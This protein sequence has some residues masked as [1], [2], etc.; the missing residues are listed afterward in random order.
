MA[1]L[2]EI[3]QIVAEAEK[4]PAG[5][6]RDAIISEAMALLDQTKEE[7]PLWQK[8]LTGAGKVLDYAGGVSR[9]ALANRPEVLLAEALASDKPVDAKEQAMRGAE[10]LKQA[11]MASPKSSSELMESRGVGEMGSTELPL[12]GKVTGRGTV[13]LLADVATD[14]TTY[15][16]AAALKPLIKSK[17]K[18]LYRSGLKNIDKAVWKKGKDMNAFS[19]AAMKYG[20]RGSAE[21]IFN[22]TDEVLEKL[23]KERDAILADAAQ[24]GAVVDTERVLKPVVRDAKKIATSSK[25][26]DSNVKSQAAKMAD[27]LEA[28]AEANKRIPERMPEPEQVP[29][30]FPEELPTKKTKVIK[31][32]FVDADEPLKSMS[33]VSDQPLMPEFKLGEKQSEVA[34]LFND[35]PAAALPEMDQYIKWLDRKGVTPDE[36]KKIVSE[37]QAAEK[38]PGWSN[39]ADS[40]EGIKQ[41]EMLSRTLGYEPEV[42][43]SIYKQKNIAPLIVEEGAYRAA[44]IAEQADLLNL[45]SYA[46]K[47][48]EPKTTT[49]RFLQRKSIINEGQQSLLRPSDVMGEAVPTPAV[50]GLTPTE[51][52]AVK[53]QLYNMIGSEPYGILRQD[54]K[55]QGL[56]KKAA[57]RFNTATTEAVRKVDPKAAKRLR[58]LNKDMSGLLTGRPAAWNEASK[59]ITKNMVTSVDAPLA[60]LNPQAYL[61]KKAADI[62]KTASFRTN[63]G[64]ALSNDMIAS[65]LGGVGGAG[66]SAAKT[67]AINAYMKPEEE[68]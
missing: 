52:S 35:T 60:L 25:V 43:R 30:F 4:L 18:D 58:E 45:E 65:L 26:I 42:V 13:G 5:A 61:G 29:A 28:F 15:V 12:L 9:A 3:E 32:T 48:L 41:F 11:L 40:E 51:S 27:D 2:K 57:A 54:K 63:V 17:G 7:T 46:S 38:L 33:S 22:Q 67:R 56:L 23:L 19:D 20:I 21:D 66:L 6:E 14:P 36:Y 64:T 44:P 31:E 59:E 39:L 24:K 62:G 49:Q 50:G 53:T 16:G 8:A 10:E 37:L 1:D 34:S 47:Q 55:G 68:K